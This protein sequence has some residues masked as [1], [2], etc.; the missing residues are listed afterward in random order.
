M[1]RSRGRRVAVVGRSVYFENHYPEGR[2]GDSH[3]VVFDPS[4]RDVT[5][6]LAV[7]DWRPDL[8]VFFRPEL[9]PIEFVERIPGR[10]VALLSEPLPT[11]N[12]G[13]LSHSNETRM[14]LAT[15]LGMPWAAFDEVLYYDENKKSAVEALRW[16]VDGYRPLPIDTERFYPS[17]NAR[18]IDVCFIGKPT[19]RRTALLDTLRLWHGRFLWV[20]HGVSGH[21]LAWLFRH[22]KVVLNVHADHLVALEPRVFLGAA[23]GC[24]VFTEDVGAVPQDIADRVVTFSGA[25]QWGDLDAAINQ[26]E[27]NIDKWCQ[28]GVLKQYSMREFLNEQVERLENG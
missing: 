14:R 4:E 3:V 18:P 27:R 13:V 23:C 8:T 10:K 20:A 2:R 26:H 6:L 16:P 5:F 12:G 22:S 28:A 24:V 19:P 17:R 15:Y 11:L 25:I 9:Y 1:Q 21:E 7:A